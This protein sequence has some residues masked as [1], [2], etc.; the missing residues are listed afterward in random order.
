MK[1]Q[2]ISSVELIKGVLAKKGYAFKMPKLGGRQYFQIYGTDGEA[3]LTLSADNPLYPFTTSSARLIAKNKLASYDF[4]KRN[5]VSIPQTVVVEVYDNL[6]NAM[7]LLQDSQTVIVKPAHGA[8][9]RGLTLDVSDQL[10][11]KHSI[12]NARQYAQSVIVQRQFFGE[13]V[14]FTVING[15]VKAAL[16][17]QKA[18]VAGNG[19]STVKQLIKEENKHR[20]MIADT[21]VAYPQLDEKLVSSQLL[22]D[23]TVL[24]KGEKRELS[25]STMIKGGAS[26]FNIYDSINKGYIKLA[27]QAAQGLGKGFIV[28]DMMIQDYTQPPTGDNYVFIEFNL[29][30]A[31]ALFYACRDENHFPVV[32]DHLAPMLEFAIRGYAHE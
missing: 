32:E 6:D 24:A 9:S 14:R 13:E 2:N 4:V 29:S 18:K 7:R 26:V 11:L 1:T 3:L 21:L 12:A 25:K 23:S 8:G 28:V 5:G 17:R 30:P 31:L 20:R 19:I 16:L 27:R 10:T 22:N 15:E